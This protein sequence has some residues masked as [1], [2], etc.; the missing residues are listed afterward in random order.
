[1]RSAAV[2]RFVCV[3]TLKPGDLVSFIFYQQS[4]S[5]AINSMGDVFTGLM[6]AAGAAEK[7]PCILWRLAC[8][9][10]YM[11]TCISVYM[12]VYIHIYIYI[13]TTHLYIYIYT[14]TAH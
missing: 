3:Q 10:M 7:V 11:H 5:Q 6:Q 1:M 4:L 12:C 14:Y 13:H 9:C 2:A 8:D